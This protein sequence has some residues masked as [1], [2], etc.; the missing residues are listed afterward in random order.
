MSLRS[1]IVVTVA[2]RNFLSKCMV[3]AFLLK[4]TKIVH[5]LSTPLRYGPNMYGRFLG[6]QSADC[7]DPTS[8]A[9]LTP[10]CVYAFISN[11]DEHITRVWYVR[12]F[13]P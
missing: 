7:F 3:D 5:I 12:R 1:P 8:Q 2:T 6:A 11:A 10:V 13:S 4:H 9:N